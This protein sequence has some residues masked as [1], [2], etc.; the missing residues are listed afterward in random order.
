MA[1][2]K[3]TKTAENLLK[4]FAGES[5]ARNRYTFYASKAKAE[6]FLQIADIF[7]ET[8]ENEKEHAKLFYKHLVKHLDPNTVQEINAGYPIALSDKTLNNLES[9][10]GGEKEEWTKLYPDFAKIADDEGFPDIARTF[11]SIALVEERHEARYRKL[12][13]NVKNGKVFKKDVKVFWIC[14]NCGEVIE[15]KDAPNKCPVCEHPQEYFQVFV[16]NY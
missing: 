7:L 4:A 10:A 9:A 3:G 15:S 16:E 1:N 14:R 5:Q 12:A 8:A 13:E 2:L 6:G 11:K